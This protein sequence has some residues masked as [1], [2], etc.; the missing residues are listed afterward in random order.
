MAALLLVFL[1]S[2]PV[3]V[4]TPQIARLRYYALENGLSGG[5]L[6][7]SLAELDWRKA[8]VWRASDTEY[9]Q[10]QLPQFFEVLTPRLY[11]HLYYWFG[12]FLWFP[13]NLLCAF[14]I[15]WL[16]AL[17]V[18]Q[19]TG[20]WGPGLVA[21]SFWLVT[22]E[23]LVGHHAPI[24]YAKD[25]ATLQILGILSLFLALRS[26]VRRRGPVVFAAGLL[27][28]LG[29]FTD[30]YVFFLLPSLL[31]ALFAW[32]WLQRVRWPLLAA[33]LLI[34]GVSIWL[35]LDVLPSVISPDRR[36]PFAAIKASSVGD[37]LALIVRN[38]RYLALNTLDIFTYT[39]GSPPPRTPIRIALSALAGAALLGTALALRAW[40][41]AGRMI[42][43]F[44][45]AVVV[46]GG[47]LLPEGNDILHQHTYYNRPLVALLMAVLGIFTMRVLAAGKG[48]SIAWLLALALAG[49]L[50]VRAV[51]QGIRY[52]PE[53]AYLTRYGLENIF[54]LHERLKSGELKPPVF[55]SY[56]QFRDVVNGVYD[57]LEP[58]PVYTLENGFPWSL[59]RTLMPRLYL[60]HFETGEIRNDPRQFARWEK[61]DEVEYRAAC[62]YFYDMPAGEAWDLEALRKAVYFKPEKLR[63]TSERGETVE[64]ATRRDLLGEAPFT[65]L[66]KGSWEAE[67]DVSAIATGSSPSSLVFAV[68]SEGPARFLVE[69]GQ[70]RSELMQTSRW[71]W[72]IISI[73]VSGGEGLTLVTDGES[74]IIGPILV[75]AD[76]MK[77]IP[78]AERKKAPPSGVPP[79]KI[80]GRDPD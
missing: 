39:F 40:K 27:F 16:I 13:L 56:P 59:Y 63:W 7:S 51:E 70:A 20:E 2:L 22:T 72:H 61:A 1:V 68:R 80:L 42:L 47:V 67:Y 3:R 31:L 76:K 34:A 37:P 38:L 58:A 28:A 54:N 15:G 46:A 5:P 23:V 60:R 8:F 73:P 33:F 48:W 19:W 26:P 62:R 30:E 11:A 49:V 6:S 17:I 74:Q 32:P 66:G 35:Y 78:L 57:E 75:P 25:F 24:R 12:P 43:F 64:S 18:R 10:R 50:N 79:L 52:D 65:V 53:E 4:A 44:G 41:G 45:I 36:A 29:G 77:E 69:A 55:I 9:R 71:S 21:G 14:L